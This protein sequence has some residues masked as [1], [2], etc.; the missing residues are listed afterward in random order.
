MPCPHLCPVPFIVFCL[1]G[2][3]LPGCVHSTSKMVHLELRAD[4]KAILNAPQLANCNING[5]V[6]FNMGNQNEGKENCFWIK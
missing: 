6:M 3:G 5:N 1:V 4:R 2:G